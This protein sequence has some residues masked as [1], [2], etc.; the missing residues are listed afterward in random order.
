MSVADASVGGRKAPHVVFTEEQLAEVVKQVH[1]VGQFCFD[2]ET[3]GVVERHPDVMDYIDKEWQEH[4]STLKATN[5]DILRRSKESIV[6]R[7]RKTLALDPLRNEIIWIGIATDGQSWAIP[8]AHP[9]G[10]VIAPAQ[11]GDGTTIPPPGFR[12]LLKSGEESMAKVKYFKPAVFS[13][14]PEQLPKSVVFPA[15]ESLF[16]G[17]L[18]KVGHN[19]KFDARSIRKYYGGRLPDGPFADTMIAQHIL[20]ENLLSYGL[21]GLIGVNFESHNAYSVGGKLGAVITEVPFSSAARYQHLDVRWTWLLYKKLYRKIQADPALLACFR[22]DMDV[23]RVL[24]DMEDNGIP[25]NQRAMKS[26][27]KQLD[28]RLNEL[29]LDMYQ[30][31][32]PGFNPGSTNHKRDLLFKG[33]REGGLGLKPSKTT[34]TG[35]A[36]VDEETLKKLES[37]HPVIPMLLEYAET[38]KLVSTYVYGLLPQLVK[39]RLHPSFHLHRTATGRLSA[40]NPNLQNIPRDSGVRGLFVAPNGYEL[41]VADYDQIELRVMCMFSGDPR[42]SAFFLN[43]EDIHAGAAALCLGKPVDEVTPDERQ[44][45]KGVNFL[46][47]YGGGYQKLSV[48]TG[49]DEGHAKYVIDQ[50]YRQF[51]GITKWKQTVVAQG[52]RLGYVTTMS[53]RRRRLP[54]LMSTDKGSRARA[55]RQGV[56]AVVQ[57]SAADICKKAMVDCYSAFR[58]YDSQLLVQVHDELVVAVPKGSADEMTPILMEAMGHGKVYDGIPLKVSCHAANSWAEAKGK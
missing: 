58:E 40:S 14:P 46:T 21:D 12:N 41:L 17:D 52:R 34:T 8:L 30:Y 47:A 37:K 3:R 1:R 44:L 6:N 5:E 15:L 19:V 50:Y 4:A 2:V 57:G 51:S 45:G 22:Q 53:G 13:A 7:W 43:D 23:L 20:N 36:S 18:V 27:G 11:S 32:P 42:M 10:E 38:K 24:M 56:N 55:E 16:F 31:A 35:G 26:L 29:M 48:T 25:V 9:N 54:D 49:I 39:G 33:K 28:Q